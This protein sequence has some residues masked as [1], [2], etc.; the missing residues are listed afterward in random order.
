ML[1]AGNA[2]LA[3]VRIF[4]SRRECNSGNQARGGQED[5]FGNRSERRR[6]GYEAEWVCWQNPPR[7]LRLPPL[8]LALAGK[9][10]GQGAKNA[11]PLR[12]SKRCTELARAQRLQYF[13]SR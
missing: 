4:N 5:G 7:Y 10:S 11:R 8:D 3:G 6:R 2:G 13:F 1:P 9:K 12:I